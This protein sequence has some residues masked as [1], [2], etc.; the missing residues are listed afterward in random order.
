MGHEG[1]RAAAIAQSAIATLSTFF[2]L[3]EASC[4]LHPRARFNPD[5][6]AT[7]AVVDLDA[8]SAGLWRS[9]GLRGLQRSRTPCATIR[10]S[11]SSPSVCPGTP[12]WPA[13]RRSAAS[14]IWPLR[15]FSRNSSTSTSPPASNGS[16]QHH[17]G[18]LPGR[19]HAGSGRHRRR[20][21]RPSATDALPRLLRPVPILPLIISEPTTKHVFVAWLRPG[22]V[23]ASIGADDDLLRVVAALRKQ[24]PDIVADAGFGL[25]WMYEVCEQNNLTYTFGFS[26]NARL[27]TL[28]EDLMKQAVDGYQQTKEKQRLFDC[29][30]YQCDSWDRT[31]RGDRQ[32]RMPRPGNQPPLHGHQPPGRFIRRRRPA[33]YDHYTQRARVSSGWMN[34][35]TACRWTA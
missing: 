4:R 35:R 30:D 7:R 32:G 19:D 6:S 8:A 3:R 17:G 26:T 31:R 27:K 15:G 16:R 25:P 10:C 12:P 24:R 23:H 5:Y 29:F 22:T 20:H 9:G 1:R 2:P 11:S 21:P 28:T 33:Q 13:S 14:R 18:Q 34:S